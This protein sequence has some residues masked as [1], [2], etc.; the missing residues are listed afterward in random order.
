VIYCDLSDLDIFFVCDV[1]DT[2][3]LGIFVR[4]AKRQEFKKQ[5]VY[6]SMHQPVTY[7]GTQ[8]QH[9]EHGT[10]ARTHA[11]TRHIYIYIYIYIYIRTVTSYNSEYTGR[12]P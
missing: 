2:E 1:S 8:D 12:P 7:F 5:S 9:E 4:S 10:V 6:V 11:H 3:K